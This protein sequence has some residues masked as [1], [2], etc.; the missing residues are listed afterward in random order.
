MF[1]STDFR[2]IFPLCGNV[3]KCAEMYGNIVTILL[4]TSAEFHRKDF[5]KVLRNSTEISWPEIECHLGT[6]HAT[7]AA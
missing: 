6:R 5:R 2:T 1:F 4:G 3:W 7:P